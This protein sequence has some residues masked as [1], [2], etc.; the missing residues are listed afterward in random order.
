MGDGL[1]RLRQIEGINLFKSDDPDSES[2]SSGKKAAFLR[3]LP[4]LVHPD[5]VSGM[6]CWHQRVRVEPKELQDTANKLIV[7]WIA[8]DLTSRPN[9][10]NVK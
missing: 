4:S 3:T 10:D 9:T 5:P 8:V 7:Q 2:E 6:H 1:W